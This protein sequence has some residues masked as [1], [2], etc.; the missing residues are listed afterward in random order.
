MNL[1]II[2]NKETI[3]IKDYGLKVLKY[4]VP[5]PSFTHVSEKIDGMDGELLIDSQFNTRDI[6]VEFLM[7]SDDIKG[8]YELK[9]KFNQLFARREEFYIIFDREKW[10]RWK[11]IL[12]SPVQWENSS[13]SSSVAE[14][15]FISHSPFAESVGTTLS[16][17]NED[18]YIQQFKNGIWDGFEP[19]VQYEFSTNNFEVFNDSDIVVDPRNKELTITFKGAS[20]N[21]KIENTTTGDVF[22]YTGSTIDTDVIE[23]KGVRHLKNGVSIFKNTN[24]KTITLDVGWNDFIISGYTGD[25]EIS[26]DARFYYV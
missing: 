8:L 9:Y 12:N 21:L 15:N 4:L 23:L 10:K 14:V 25:F 24:R 2:T 19:T 6:S 18:S 11:V 3:F 17:S 7:L 16:P 22:E 13:N 26:I 1:K 20:T 5:S